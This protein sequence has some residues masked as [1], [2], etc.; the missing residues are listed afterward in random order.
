MDAE[1]DG[2]RFDKR[3]KRVRSAFETSGNWAE[4]IE[5]I[6]RATAFMAGAPG[7]EKKELVEVFA[8]WLQ[9]GT[10]WEVR[11]AIAG[12]LGESGLPAAEPALEGLKS[13]GNRWVRQAAERALLRARRITAQ[14]DRPQRGP[15]YAFR[16]TRDLGA[17]AYDAALDVAE[18]WYAELAADMA[19]EVNTLVAVLLGHEEELEEALRRKGWGDEEIES[20]IERLRGGTEFLGRVVKGLREYSD[21]EAEFETVVLADAVRQAVEAAQMKTRAH[22][23]ASTY[24]CEVSIDEALAVEGDYE[25]IERALSNVLSN[26]IEA[27][28][29]GGGRIQVTASS[30]AEGEVEI[31]VRDNGRGIPADQIENVRKRFRSLRK[32]QGG[33]GLGLPIAIAIVEKVH[34]GKLGIESEKGKGTTVVVRLPKR[35]PAPGEG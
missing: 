31:R 27:L 3:L 7:P 22:R 5:A 12:C 2:E 30:P 24:D 26:A 21:R 28:P 9:G 8:S 19:H 15:A 1:G 20:R 17:E 11:R 33:V 14:S 25:K 34:G 32:D 23:E 35:R 4:D 10:K 29:E 16:R 13:D 6:E 18:E